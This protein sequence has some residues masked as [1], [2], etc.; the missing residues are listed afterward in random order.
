MMR[1]RALQTGSIKLQTIVIIGVVALAGLVAIPAW[2][3][4]ASGP[5]DAVLASNT[6]AVG[7]T[8]AIALAQGPSPSPL[9]TPSPET[10]GTLRSLF[11]KT[12][13]N[14][15]THSTTIASGDAWPSGSCAPAVW[16][17]SRADA[18]SRA[19]AAD[20]QR[21]RALAGTIVVHIDATG[22]DI[23]AVAS[24]GAPLPGLHYASTD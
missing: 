21:G 2:A 19:L 24:R 11:A 20:G 3:S 14:P 23:F 13:A 12:V 1:S 5:R 15:V 8:Y 4:R 18:T 7:E 16:I 22:I 6:R 17:T 9:T 10:A